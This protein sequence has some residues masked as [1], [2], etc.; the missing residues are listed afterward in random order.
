M[1]TDR[2]QEVGTLFVPM[3]YP[4]REAE[5]VTVA[6]WLAP[7][8][9]AEGFAHPASVASLARRRLKDTPQLLRL[10]PYVASGRYAEGIDLAAESMRA[11]TSL[12]VDL[13]ADR[14]WDFLAV[15][16]K[17]DRCRAGIGISSTASTCSGGPYPTG[18]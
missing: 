12:A 10:G 14:R 1:L 8:I 9:E 3:T 7:S 4:A 6:G 17:V 2:G 11:R 16:P 5:W 18:G 13:L 15:N